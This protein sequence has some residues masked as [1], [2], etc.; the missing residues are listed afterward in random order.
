MEDLVQAPRLAQP[1][2]QLAVGDLET[3]RGILFL[4]SRVTPVITQP[5]ELNQGDVPDD[6]RDVS[7][8]LEVGFLFDQLLRLVAQENLQLAALETFLG[9][10]F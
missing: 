5:S 1:A 10:V 8:V 3:K 7:G 2:G 9:V 4:E 6:A